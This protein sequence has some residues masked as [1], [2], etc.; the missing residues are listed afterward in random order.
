MGLL[1][2]YETEAFS[3]YLDAPTSGAQ[4]LIFHANSNLLTPLF[5]DEDLTQMVSNPVRADGEGIF[6][7]CYT[8]NGEYCAVV[9]DR[10][11]RRVL[12]VSSII[13]RS[14]QTTTLAHEFRSIHQLRLD[15]RKQYNAASGAIRIH[16]GELFR[17][18]GGAILYEIAEPDAADHHI[19][20]TGGL[21]LYMQPDADGYYPVEGFGF[22][23]DGSPEDRDRLQRACNTTPYLKFQPRTYD[24]GAHVATPTGYGSH[25]RCCILAH[26]S[27]A[28][29]S[30]GQVTLRISDTV[31][32]SAHANDV[33]ILFAEDQDAFSAP[34]FVFDQNSNAQGYGSPFALY[35]VSKVDLDGITALNAGAVRIGASP[36][37]LCGLVTGHITVQSGTG[38]F[39]VGGK[40]GG[41][42][43][44]KG[45][46]ADID[47]CR[48]GVNI[49]CE[50][51]NGFGLNHRTASATLGRIMGKNLV[52]GASPVEF[53]KVEDG[54]KWVDVEMISLDTAQ[55][56]GTGRAAAL[57]V[58][59]GQDGDGMDRVSVGQIVGKDILQ[60]IY[61]EMRDV[62]Q[63]VVQVGSIEAEN[64]GTLLSCN[65]TVGTSVAQARSIVIRHVQ[66]IVQS[67]TDEN[68]GTAFSVDSDPS[69]SGSNAR[70]PHL[71]TLQIR[72]GHLSSVGERSFNVRGV[73]RF[74]C[75]GLTVDAHRSDAPS[76][77]YAGSVYNVIEADDIILT[78]TLLK[79]FAGTGVPLELRPKVS[80]VLRGLD[81]SAGGSGTA[82]FLNGSGRVYLDGCHFSGATNALNFRKLAYDFD[83]SS[84]DTATQTI[85]VTGHGFRHGEQVHYTES[86][87]SIG[88]LT[89][90]KMYHVIFVD[91]D[92]ISLSTSLRG[93]PITLSSGASG[94]V[95]LRK[96]MRVK[97]VNTRNDCSNLAAYSTRPL[98][99]EA[100]GTW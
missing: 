34:G 80:C 96:A 16:P 6:P 8:V 4:L 41:A 77:D 17:V 52:G 62:P 28:W 13:V 11:G 69:D 46:S 84:V 63:G 51:V 30:V 78:N 90:G 18:A 50:D 3:A 95:S 67:P 40:P 57:C 47:G 56:T 100:S 55:S 64:I 53:V 14:A 61:L 89:D 82:L 21:K 79:D 43:N 35:G 81:L 27:I 5:K 85:G 97:L 48:G 15:R 36:S 33:T 39:A 60:A 25:K 59:Q 91:A 23:G 10:S 76:G 9:R 37:R 24:I 45:V 66:G 22:T 88:G 99:F 72:G 26:S 93:T 12:D 38:T 49:E 2:L 70:P 42:L 92:R 58:K 98:S 44:W 65:N 68:R 19:E 31:Q 71:D 73:R 83:A 7:T 94:T 20:T 75:H 86:G 74:R 32:Q 1:D 54:A 29:R 87:G